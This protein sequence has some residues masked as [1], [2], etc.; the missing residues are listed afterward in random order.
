MS[1]KS[2]LL[3]TPSAP[4]LIHRTVRFGDQLS[5]EDRNTLRAVVR[6]VHRQYL[7]DQPSTTVCDELIDALGPAAQEKMLRAAINANGSI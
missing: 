6:K 1:T 4:A 2:N 3:A 5:F 7:P